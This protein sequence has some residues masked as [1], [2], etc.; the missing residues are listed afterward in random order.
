MY[1]Y[2]RN[3]T[4]MYICIYICIHIY[5]FIYLFYHHA[6]IH[7]D[8]PI[9][10]VEKTAIHLLLRH[11]SRICQAPSFGCFWNRKG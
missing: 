1:I 5:I 11:R 9:N 10:I 8:T 4:Y 2:V 6:C 3:C 7:L